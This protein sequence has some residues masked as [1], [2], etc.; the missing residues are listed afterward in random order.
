MESNSDIRPKNVALSREA[1][2]LV[3]DDDEHVRR[4]L[5]RV[6]RRTNCAFLEAPEAATALDILARE[7]V[8]VVVSDYRMPGMDGVEFLRLVKERYP[9]I[10]RVLLTGQ[11]D[12]AAIEEAV[13]R[14][15]IFR[16]IWKPWDETHLLLTVQDA[17]EQFWMIEENQRLQNMLAARQAELERL[18]RDLDAKLEARTEALRLAAQEWRTCFDA[19]AD[20]LAIV[21]GGCEVVRA[22]MAFARHAGVSV[23]EVHGLHCVD[24]TF[25]ELP[26]PRPHLAEAPER[27]VTLRSRVWLMR[28]FPFGG[29]ALVVV[30]KDVTQEREVSRRLFQA[31]KMS[32]L[33]QLAGGVAHEI[34]NPLGGILAFAQIMAQDERSTD[35]QESLR[36]ISDAAMRA[37]RIVDS[38]LRFSRAPKEHERGPVDLARVVEEALLI[39]QPNLRDGRLVVTK[40]LQPGPHARQRQPAPA[41]DGEPHR[42]R[43]AGHRGEGDHRHPH[44]PRRARAGRG[45]RVR[46]RPRG[47]RRSGRAHLRPVLHHQAGR[48]GD[49]PGPVHL[50]PHRRG[51]RRRGP[52]GEP[53]GGRRALRRRPAGRTRTVTGEKTMEETVRPARVLVVDDE[54]SVLRALEVIL[55]KKGHEV[56]ALDSPI[57]ATQRLAVEDFD[58]AMLDIR[59]PELSGIELLNAV[60]H[61]RPEIEVIMMTG[62]ATVDTAL[63]AM[64]AGAHDYLIKPFI[65][66]PDDVEH[67][68]YVVARAAERKRLQDRNRELETR[69]EALETTQGLVG[70]SGPMREVGRMIEAVAYSAATVLVQ[71][72]SGTGKEL[73]ARALHAR[74][75][76]RAHPF[77]ALNCGA[78]TET[79]LESELFGHVKGSFTGANRDHKGLFESANGGTIFLDEIGDIPLSTQVRLLRVL[80]EGEIKK[81]GSTDPVKVD[82]RVIA[83]THRD[84]P[85]LV[86][87]GKFR[88]DLFYRLNVIAIPLPPLRERLDDVPL[89]AHHFVRRY[90]DRL[91]KKVRTLA[92]AAIELLCVYRWPGNVRELE[93]AIERAVVLCRADS[94]QPTDLPP[95]ITG[96]TAPVLREAS[97]PS[98]DTELLAQSYATAKDN[99]LR[100]FEKRYVEA[101]MRACDNNISAAARKAGMD[102]SNFKR[103]L[104]K[105]RS[106]VED[107]V[108]GDNLPPEAM[109]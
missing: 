9:A 81:V 16:F 61:R 8:H 91:G 62:H 11:A 79:L 102:R 70:T 37:K 25:G 92:P 88:E 41:G 69:L 108:E 4:S 39:L 47:S 12:T 93:N 73:V 31:E 5:R 24:H 71:G 46:R 76:R 36:L 66:K 54:P 40:D 59:M 27:V 42:Q 72:E 90:S 3:V 103:V 86:R 85:K 50:L 78:L 67:V 15:E 74:S 10:Q 55:R 6:L 28:A 2:V 107:D 64:K 80:Q 77:V 65:E 68:A 21:R 7:P 38:L 101:L 105:Y 100:N 75:P 34:N 52:A 26:C 106:D 82:V 35:D 57:A 48:A 53:P 89:L 19:I 94:V 95:S 99:A 20:P 43:L 96:R 51:A 17:I 84:L 56:V 63:A 49:G 13:N 22:N 60:K 33:G 1:A 23:S 44:R 58:V 83:A 109:V 45:D 18:N 97:Q 32:A 14:S 29:D 30:W 104:R 87:A 98:D